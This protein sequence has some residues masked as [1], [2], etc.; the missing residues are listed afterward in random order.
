MGKVIVQLSTYS[1]QLQQ[2]GN[3]GSTRPPHRIGPLSPG[4]AAIQQV[5][6]RYRAA[7]EATNQQADQECGAAKWQAKQGAQSCQV[8]G[9]AGVSMHPPSRPRVPS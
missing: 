3:R 9:Q 4:Q 7:E 2:G 6:A 5:I 8:A 1:I